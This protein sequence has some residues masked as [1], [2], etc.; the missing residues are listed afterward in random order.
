[1]IVIDPR[2]TET[3]AAADI[4]LQVRPGGDLVLLN[5]MIGEIARGGLLDR[6]YLERHVEGHREMLEAAGAWSTQRAAAACGVPADQ[7][8]RAAY[9]FAGG[10]RRA[11]ALVDGRQPELA[12]TAT[13]RALI[14]LCLATGHMAVPGLARS[15]SPDSRTRWVGVRSAASRTCCRATARSTAPR[16]APR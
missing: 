16:T 5:A 6:D 4:H 12:G 13:N 3:A 11:R 10:R 14:N 1:M 7:I 8:S 9:Q 2:R 15:R